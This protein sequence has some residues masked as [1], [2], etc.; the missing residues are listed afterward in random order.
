[1]SPNDFPIYMEGVN[2]GSASFE[3]I[4]EAL[5]LFNKNKPIA[6][7][8]VMEILCALEVCYRVPDKE[9]VF[10][11]PALIEERRRDAMWKDKE[12]MIVYV[13]R[14]LQCRDNTDIIVPG[15]IRSWNDSFSSDAIGRISRS[16]SNDLERRNGLGKASD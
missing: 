12:D 4:S 6:F 10:R 1:M 13:G 15:T 11:F 7:D 9:N 3:R 2:D 16:M 8:E 5:R 14:R